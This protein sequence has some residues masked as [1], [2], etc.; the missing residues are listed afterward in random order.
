M[1]CNESNI[2]TQ[3]RRSQHQQTTIQQGLAIVLQ[4]WLIP[5]MGWYKIHLEERLKL[6]ENE[7]VTV[8][9]S[10]YQI[11]QDYVQTLFQELKNI[12]RQ[13]PPVLLQR[14]P[15]AMVSMLISM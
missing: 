14:I 7:F 11:D 15:I 3:V 2:S 8:P 4:H 10:P 5:D 9:S 13:P 12:L 6:I 1:A